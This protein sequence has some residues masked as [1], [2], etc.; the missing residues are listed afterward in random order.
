[1][2]ES[3]CGIMELTSNIHAGVIALGD[4]LKS[5][6]AELVTRRFRKTNKRC[7]DDDRHFFSGIKP[8]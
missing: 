1:M 7:D 8:S 3:E 4:T 6:N 2:G 5:E